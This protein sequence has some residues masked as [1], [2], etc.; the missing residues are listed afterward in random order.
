MRKETTNVKKDIT[1]SNWSSIKIKIKENR[2]KYKKLFEKRLEEGSKKQS[3]WDFSTR[4]PILKTQLELSPTMMGMTGSIL[5]EKNG[6]LRLEVKIPIDES[7]KKHKSVRFDLRHEMFEQQ[8][9]SEEN[10]SKEIK[11]G[12]Q[13]KSKNKNYRLRLANPGIESLSTITSPLTQYYT[14]G[15]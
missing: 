10:N 14:K 15:R 1:I 5:K 8:V 12:Q 11:N 2:E 9:S 6:E 4:L 7:N 3:T 13:K